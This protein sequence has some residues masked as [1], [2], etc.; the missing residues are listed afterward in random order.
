MNWMRET[1]ARTFAQD[2]HF[3]QVVFL[4]GQLVDTLAPSILAA[5]AISGRVAE[6]ILKI[7]IQRL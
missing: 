6:H 2:Y 7:E 1:G 3:H 4:H 5:S